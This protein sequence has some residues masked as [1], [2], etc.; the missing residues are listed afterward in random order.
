MQNYEEFQKGVDNFYDLY[1]KFL[2][3]CFQDNKIQNQEMYYS[4]VLDAYVNDK[5]EI[6]RKYKP[7]INREQLSYNNTN[8]SVKIEKEYNVTEVLCGWG[9][10]K[11]FILNTSK[12]NIAKRKQK[13]E[14]D[15]IQTNRDLKE[16]ERRLKIQAHD[17]QIKKA[18]SLSL[19]VFLLISGISIMSFMF[20][21]VVAGTI[22]LAGIIFGVLWFAGSVSAAVFLKEISKTYPVE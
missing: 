19:S 7:A 4:S 8:S 5:L 12:E 20:Y 16:V 13:H 14:T 6:P 11:L 22:N 17:A 15:P 9:N 1:N 2:S 21:C 3:E 18:G 10:E